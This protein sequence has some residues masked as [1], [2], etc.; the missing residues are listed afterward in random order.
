[1]GIKVIIRK[2]RLS[3]NDLWTARV[4]GDEGEPK[5][6]ANVIIP[7]NHPAVAQLDAAIAEAAKEKWKEKTV[8]MM[9][10]LI[11][12]ERLCLHKTTRRK[13]AT[14]EPYVG[15]EN[16]YWLSATSKTRPKV[17][18]RDGVSEVGPQD[19]VIYSGCY[20]NL[21]IDVFA[22]FHPKGGNRVLAGLLGVMFV[23]DG[24]PFGGG[25]ASDSDFAG[26]AE[27][28]YGES[29]ASDPMFQ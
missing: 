1:M 17:R 13:A 22:N 26:L 9:P 19:G 12:Q 14:G 7:P 15:Y 4:Q 2:A 21:I 5:F 28:G 10:M 16:M 20:V 23:E 24:E 6:A 8:A 25:V 11:A 27:S 18:N 29:L 3:F